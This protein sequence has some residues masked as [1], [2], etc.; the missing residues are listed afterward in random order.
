MYINFV[1]LYYIAFDASDCNRL[2]AQLMLPNY[3]AKNL[4]LFRENSKFTLLV[5][6]QPSTLIL[7]LT[8]S[9]FCA[10]CGT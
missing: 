5:V 4:H 7:I 2:R 8:W 1:L 6:I 9:S 10:T 3:V